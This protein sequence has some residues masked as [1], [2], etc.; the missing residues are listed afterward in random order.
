MN[1]NGK[2][3]KITSK[4]IKKVLS[5]RGII[6]ALVL[7]CVAFAFGSEY[8]LKMR[9]IMNIG[10]FASI[11]G[12]MASGLTVA[13]L[14][15]GLD[16]SQY[17]LAAFVGMIMG[18]MVENNISPAI[19][20]ITALAVSVVVGFITSMV[21][22]KMRVNP[23]IAT[24]GMQFIL[25]GSA[26]LLTNGRYIRI[27]NDVFYFIG[28]GKIFGI[29]PFSLLIMAFCYLAVWYILKYTAYGRQVYAVGGN[30]TVAKLAGINVNGIKS[31]SYII[32]AV[33]AAIGGII[34]V[35]QTSAA[36]PTHGNG[37]D[38]DGISAV[39]LGGISLAG[40]KGKVMG[41]LAGILILAVLVNGMTLL[42]V[43]AYWQKVIK[44]IVLILAVFLDQLKNNE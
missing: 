16:V 5:E 11:M 36:M 4:Q 17:S 14:L 37:N 23:I 13:M 6:I 29:I 32:S 28:N 38:L 31:I 3:K 9:N 30:P 35:A 41:T 10:A 21:V 43:Q 42:N 18:I 27:D 8:F 19:A 40:G 12:T 26:Y 33:T 39:I 2:A 1:E 22:T 24:I 25:R 7:L 15:G 34:T 44:G 20:I